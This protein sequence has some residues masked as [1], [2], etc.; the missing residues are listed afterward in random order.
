MIKNTC[1][2]NIDL[3]CLNICFVFIIFQ[4][5]LTCIN[6]ELIENRLNEY[7][8]Q[9]MFAYVILIL[10]SKLEEREK[11]LILGGKVVEMNSEILL[12]TQITL[13]IFWDKI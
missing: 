5:F 2:A 10:K 6:F 8:L 4:I 3:N 11:W 9:L 1:I 13:N 12:T 7:Y